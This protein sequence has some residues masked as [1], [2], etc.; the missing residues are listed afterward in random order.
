MLF[1]D[2]FKYKQWANAELLALGERQLNQMPESDAEFFVRI[3]NHTTVV[4]SLFI[5]RLSGEAEC[6]S[7]DNT[8]E[9]PTFDELRARIVQNDA[10][11][12]TFAERATAEELQR[13]IVFRFTDGDLGQL[14]VEEVLLHLLTHGSNH[15]G[16]AARTL[17]INGLER[18]KD[19]FTRYLHE[20]QP[21]R[22]ELAREAL[23]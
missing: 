20:A 15:R 12:V 23:G 9:T 13:V 1:A 18:P 5:S 6:Y 21:G 2:A 4:D 16:M 22:R 7:G 3:L 17:A 19:T 10:W 11:L 8:R 14:S